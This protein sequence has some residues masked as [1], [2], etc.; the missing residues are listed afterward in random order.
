MALNRV[1]SAWQWL[2]IGAAAT[3]HVSD[4]RLKQRVISTEGFVQRSDG[5]FALAFER[6]D[7]AYTFA[8]KQFGPDHMITIGARFNRANTLYELGRWTEAERDMV[9]I[10]A[11]GRRALG[12]KHQLLSFPMVVAAEIALARGHLADAREKYLGVMRSLDEGTYNLEYVHEGLGQIALDEGKLTQ[13]REELATSRDLVAKI[14]ADRPDLLR[15]DARVALLDL[16][17][18]HPEKARAAPLGDRRSGEG[19]RAALRRG[20]V[21]P[22]RPRPGRARHPAP[23]PRAR[24]GGERGR[25]V[26]EAPR[27]EPPVHARGPLDRRRRAARARPDRRGDRPGRGD[28]SPRRSRSSGRTPRWSRARTSPS[29]APRSRPETSPPLAASSTRPRACPRC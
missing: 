8:A 20:V 10:L 16:E 6:L 15:I 3:E 4:P 12:P 11:T 14:S 27:R 17:E 24:A 29:A 28:D 5:K 9:E 7:Q 25:A 21:R 19:E 18:G 1:P 23:R 2:R 26:D 13:A 22:A